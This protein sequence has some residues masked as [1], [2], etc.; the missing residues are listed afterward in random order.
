MSHLAAEDGEPLPSEV[1]EE[2]FHALLAKAG[3]QLNRGRNGE[4]P[5]QLDTSALQHALRHQL[6]MDGSVMAAF[7]AGLRMYLEDPLKVCVS[8]WLRSICD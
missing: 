7:L 2:L 4:A 8:C 5:L 6:L 1:D 3:M